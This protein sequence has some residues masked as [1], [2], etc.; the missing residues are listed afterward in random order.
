M[1]RTPEIRPTREEFRELART[2]RVIPV[3]ASVVADAMTPIGLY[4][5][6][7]ARDGDPRPGTFL[8][9]SANE[10]ASW[11]RWSFIGV[12]SRATLTAKDGAAHWQG[13]VPAGAP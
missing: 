9:E 11:S 1:T 5:A 7:V 13:T 3:R 12:S 8:L 6:L 2:R 4:R 10:S